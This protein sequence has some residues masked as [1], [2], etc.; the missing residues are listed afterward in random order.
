MAVPKLTTAR[1]LLLPLCM[2]DAPQI[3]ARFPR[4]EVVRF[5]SNRIPWPYPVDG[6]SHFIRELALP[7]MAEGREWHWTIRPQEAPGELIGLISLMR[8]EGDN[9][10]FWMDPDWRGRGLM[11]EA[12]DAVTDHW[13][14]PLGQPVLR[15]PKAAA[16]LPSRRI[17]ERS[18]MRLIA[19]TERDYVSGRLPAEIWEITREEWWA[20]RPPLA[21]E[22]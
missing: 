2:A 12:C 21:S 11:T 4:W 17:S 20:R 9:R 3:Q 7:A 5:L 1:L 22:A 16:N 19:T 13:F 10:G 8:Q 18:G 6:A 14:G 15:V